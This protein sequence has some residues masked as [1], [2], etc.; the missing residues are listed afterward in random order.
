MKVFDTII[1][2]SGLGGLVTAAI[3]AKEGQRVLVLEKGKKTGGFL[4]TFKREQS[5][6]NT[7]MNYIGSLEENGLLFQYFNYLG[8]MSELNIQ[9]LD[10]DGFEEISFE[11]DANKYYYS[12]GKDEFANRLIQDFPQEAQA[13][14]NYTNKLWDITEKFPLLYLQNYDQIVKGQD[15]MNGG[16]WDFINK[17]TSNPKLKQVLAATNSLYAGV[18]DKTPLYVHALVNRQFIE[19]AWRFVNGSQQLAD[20]LAQK[21]TQNGGEILNRSQVVKIATD[22]VDQTWVETSSGERFF[23][24]T[25]VSNIHPAT[26]LKMLDDQRIKHV[27][28]KRITELPN[29]ASFFNIYIVFKPNQFKY[30]NKNIYHFTNDHIWLPY[31]K[32]DQW[33]SYFMFYTGCSKK[34]Q[35][36][37]D[38]AALM[39]YMDYEEVAK[40]KGSI[41]GMRGDE[42]ESFKQQKAEILLA[43]LEKRFPGIKKS[44]QSYYTATP[45]TYEHYNAAPQGSAYGIEKDHNNPYKSIILPKTKIP[46]LYFTGQNLNMHGA[47][48]VTIGAVLT[49]G[50]IL[51]LNYLIDKIRSSL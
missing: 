5:V 17:V 45:L 4:H 28:R 49:S 21:I 25:I 8:I 44:I 33:P 15:Y 9:P 32:K 29:T 35:I 36:W 42:Y 31:T 22:S 43:Q 38:N 1:I 30:I 6:F 13:I 2:G 7:G 12:Q 16:A 23:G 48:G 40:W 10:R 34:N 11:G 18:Q 19:S 37:A 47:L 51:G 14:N 50:E 3:L 39:T 46:N 24:K 41:K 27:Y 26:T 20:A